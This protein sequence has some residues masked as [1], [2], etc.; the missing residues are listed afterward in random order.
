AL[1]GFGRR[2]YALVTS[3][4]GLGAHRVLIAEHDQVAELAPTFYASGPDASKERLAAYLA[5]LD[6]RGTL[7]IPNPRRAADQFCH[8]IAG[9]CTL[10]LLSGMPVDSSPKT[11]NAQVDDAVDLFLRGYAVESKP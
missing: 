6:A 2:L 4:A 11:V 1:V 9:D 5:E 10:R 7:R 3:P 8:L